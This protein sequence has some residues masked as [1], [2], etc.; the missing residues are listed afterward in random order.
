MTLIALSSTETEYIGL[1]ETIRETISLINLVQELKKRDFNISKPKTKTVC[2]VFEKNSG[3]IEIVN[4]N[5][6]CP[7]TKHIN[8]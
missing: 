7:R 3:A 8:I 1:S 6:F 4:E 5:K 2:K